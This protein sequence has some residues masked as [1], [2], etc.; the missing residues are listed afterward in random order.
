MLP[1]PIIFNVKLQEQW[2]LRR[3]VK[4]IRTRKIM[5][6]IFSG[7]TP[8][9]LPQ[10]LI[11]FITRVLEWHP[12][13]L[14]IAHYYASQSTKECE[15]FIHTDIFI[16]TLSNFCDK[17]FQGGY[18]EGGK[19]VYHYEAFLNPATIPNLEAEIAKL[20]MNGTVELHIK[21]SEK[22]ILQV[23]CFPSMQF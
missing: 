18:K 5:K 20:H 16:V 10:R 13:G 22:A 4:S 8:M 1:T 7:S 3:M 9:V 6:D 21:P 11:L 2:V 19:Y 15:Y 17:T 12:T 23:C 14:G